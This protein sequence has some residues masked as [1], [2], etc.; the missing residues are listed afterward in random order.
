VVEAS[1]SVWP[2]DVP[3]HAKDPAQHSLDQV[4]ADNSALGYLAAFRRELNVSV[5]LD[6]YQSVFGQPL[7]RKRYSGSCHRKPVSQRCRDDSL[8]LGFSLGD[9]F[10]VIFF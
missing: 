6:G 2:I 10:E 9:G 8:A 5:P 7:Q 4:V 1:I 3:R